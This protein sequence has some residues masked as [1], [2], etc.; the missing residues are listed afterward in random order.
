MTAPDRAAEWSMKT[1]YVAVSPAAYKTKAMEDY[2]EGFPAATVARDQLEHAV[3]ELSV[4]D[5]GRIYKFVN[6]AVQSAVTGAQ[7]PKDALAAAQQQADRVL[8]AYK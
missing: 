8:R 5:N 2:A 6:D 3:P 1:G 4:H 7:T